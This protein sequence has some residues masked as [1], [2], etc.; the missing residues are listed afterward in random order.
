[1]DTLTNI[2]CALLIVFPIFVSAAEI[3]K[4]LKWPD[5]LRGIYQSGHLYIGG[6]P[7]SEEAL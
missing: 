6:Q 2:G 1:L 7:L 4:K 3:L 5:F